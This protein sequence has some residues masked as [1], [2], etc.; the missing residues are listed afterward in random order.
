ALDRPGDYCL[1]CDTAN[2]DA[3]VAE[4]AADRATITMLWEDEVLGRTDIPTTPEDDDTLSAIQV[5]NFAGRIADE[6]RRKRPER[7]YVTG[8]RQVIQSLR[9]DIRYPVYRVPDTDPVESVLEHREDRELDVI[10]KPPAQKIGGAH[11]TMIGGRTGQRAIQI[12]ASHPNVKKVVPGPIDAGGSSSRT[13]TRAKVTRADENGNVRLLVHESS[14][15]Q[16]NRIVTTAGDHETG[17]R[18][19]AALNEALREAGLAGGE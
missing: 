10:E 15:I 11:S 9:A 7:V 18:V 2:T 13:G 17:E 14:S 8:D 6:I 3:V 16:E 4:I 1:E 12:V 5:R 19:R